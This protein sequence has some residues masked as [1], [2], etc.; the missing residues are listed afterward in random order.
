MTEKTVQGAGRPEP[1]APLED[2]LLLRETK[3]KDE[4]EETASNTS[5]DNYITK[6][7]GNKVVSIQFLQVFVVFFQANREKQR[8]APAE[9]QGRHDVYN[10]SADHTSTVES[11]D[12]P[13]QDNTSLLI[14]AAL[15][16]ESGSTGSG[17]VDPQYSSEPSVSVS[18]SR[19]ASSTPAP[20]SAE[21]LLMPAAPK[22][23]SGT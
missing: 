21:S 1:S 3:L 9:V 5:L 20:Y 4:A 15:S 22:E 10:F 6:Y 13:Q 2:G 7:C 23:T 12:R 16:A 11:N 19:P 17:T 8:W 14:E 18:E